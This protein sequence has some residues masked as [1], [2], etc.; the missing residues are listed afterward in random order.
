MNLKAIPLILL[1]VSH[2]LSSFS[3]GSVPNE[4]WLNESETIFFSK[5]LGNE[6][7]TLKSFTTTWWN[8]LIVQ[9]NQAKERL[10][11]IQALCATLPTSELVDRIECG[12]DLTHYL[13]IAKAWAADTALREPAPSGEFLRRHLESA[14]T[15]ASLPIPK[16]LMALLRADPLESYTQLQKHALTRIPLDLEKDGEIFFDLKTSRWVLPLRPTF[17]PQDSSPTVALHQAIEAGLGGGG[18]TLLGPH[19]SG[20]ENRQQIH[21][22]LETVSWIGTLL[23]GLFVVMLLWLRWFRLL[24]AIPMVFVGMG[25]ASLCTIA[26]FGSIHGIVLSFGGG[27]VGLTLDYSIHAAFNSTKEKVWRSNLVGLA[28]TLGAWFVIFFSQIPLLR[29]LAFFSMVGLI[30]SF[31]SVYFLHRN[32]SPKLTLHPLAL[33]PLRSRF[34]SQLAIV[35]AVGILPAFFW[36]RPSFDIGQFNYQSPSTQQNYRWL[37]PH[38]KFG[39]P[40]FEVLPGETALIAAHQRA[41]WAQKEA[42][43]L[44]SAAFY[45]PLPPVQEANLESWRL[46]FCPLPAFTLSVQ[47]NRFFSPFLESHG[48]Q[49]LVSRDLTGEPPVYLS[50]LT[51]N[52]KWIALWF[53]K[54]EDDREKIKTAYPQATSLVELVN[55]FPQVLSRELLWM[56]P[57]SFL[58]IFIMLWVHYRRWGPALAAL[59]PFAVGIGLVSWF[60]L[61]GMPFSFVSLV[62]VTIL[63]GLGVDYG[64]FAVDHAIEKSNDPQSVRDGELTSSLLFAALTTIAGYLPLIF[65]GHQVLAH[66]GQVLTLGSLGATLGA[67]WLVPI[68]VRKPI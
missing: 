19:G 1:F 41:D 49:R 38:F 12:H 21:R 33:T 35:L 20:Y 46:A 4:K 61:M 32:Y 27:I 16:E 6:I 15:K 17:S 55:Q 13:A 36:V 22:D 58:I 8:F 62:G 65:C 2:V 5:K 53:P 59:S 10:P 66:L 56:F 47:E 63:L 52:G 42:I 18:W 57:L 48:C 45:L 23:M 29:Q 14:L 25:A 3:A 28:T 43:A 9:D 68:L 51:A 67:F 31:F 50:H 37:G 24:W 44:E 39:K 40:L 26:L 11:L 64:I 30:V 7:S 34:T 54:N 60:T